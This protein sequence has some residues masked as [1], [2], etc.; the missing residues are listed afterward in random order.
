MAKH[1]YGTVRVIPADPTHMYHQINRY[2][3]DWL[4]PADKQK[5]RRVNDAPMMKGV[6]EIHAPG[7]H[8]YDDMYAVNSPFAV[9]LVDDSVHGPSFEC[10]REWVNGMAVGFEYLSA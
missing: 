10:P 5:P 6:Y 1:E 2:A 3:T 7:R 4:I 9:F 8:R